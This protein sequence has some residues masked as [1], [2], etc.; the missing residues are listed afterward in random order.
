MVDSLKKQVQALRQQLRDAN[1]RYHVLDEPTIS[2][3][4]YDRLLREL[5]NIEAAHPELIT[6]DS[7]TQRVGA[8]PI[9]SFSTVTHQAPM[10]SLANAFSADEMKEFDER[11]RDRLQTS[12][13]H[14]EYAAE[15]K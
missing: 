4:E 12:V 3:A 2:D 8:S 5:D 9:D 7:P 11:V 1:Y 10:L 6:S 13:S 15:P 14:V